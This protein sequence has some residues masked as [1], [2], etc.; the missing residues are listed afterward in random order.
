MPSVVFPD[1]IIAARI[2]GSRVQQLWFEAVWNST[3]VRNQL[4]RLV[5]T[6]N[7]TIKVNQSMLET[8]DVPLP[9]RGLQLRFAERSRAIQRLRAAHQSSLAE[10]DALFVSLQHRAFRGEL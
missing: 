2:D 8:I 9:K 4:A 1:T 7:G 10:I 3:L 6:T 5:R